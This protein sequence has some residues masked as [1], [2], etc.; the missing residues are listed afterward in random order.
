METY[1]LL[2]KKSSGLGI[3]TEMRGAFHIDKSVTSSWKYSNYKSS[4]T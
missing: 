2:P 1:T 3:L 4:Y